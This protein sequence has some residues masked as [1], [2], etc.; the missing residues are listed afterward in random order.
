VERRAQRRVAVHDRLPLQF[1]ALA[2]SL[3]HE[4]EALGAHG[5][6]VLRAFDCDLA[7]ERAGELGRHG[8]RAACAFSSGEAASSCRSPTDFGKANAT[9]TGFEVEAGTVTCALRVM[10]RNV[11]STR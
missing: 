9:R 11:A 6:R 8:L 3:F 5:E 7:L 4:L 1:H 2:P 10:P